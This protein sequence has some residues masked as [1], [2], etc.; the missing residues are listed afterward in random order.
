MTLIY[1]GPSRPIPRPVPR[2]IQEPRSSR[3]GVSRSRR[4]GPA[5]PGGAP[6]RYGGTGV[7]M[8]VAP[9]RG[10]TVTPLETV[11]LALLAGLITLW[12]GLVA[13][14]AGMANDAASGSPAKVPDTLA[15]VRVEGRRSLRQSS[16]KRSRVRPQR[17]RL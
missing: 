7:T 2:P 8:S 14:F 3:S 13:D 6:L 10:R 5:R 9:H 17:M 4:P 1:A 16:T 11:G 15:V 12:L